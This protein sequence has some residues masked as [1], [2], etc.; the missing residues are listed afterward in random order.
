MEETV[1]TINGENIATILLVAA[2]GFAVLRIA[3]TFYN[4]KAGA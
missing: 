1:L 3:V 4:S 2:V